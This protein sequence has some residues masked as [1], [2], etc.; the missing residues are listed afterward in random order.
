MP[1]VNEKLHA[2][3]DNNKLYQVF[4]SEIDVRRDD[5][6]SRLQQ[7][8][9]KLEEL[10]IVSSTYKKYKN[11]VEQTGSLWQTINATQIA[12]NREIQEK[13]SSELKQ[14]Y[15]WVFDFY[16]KEQNGTYNLDINQIKDVKI[17]N[18]EDSFSNILKNQDQVIASAIN[19]Y[20][21]Y[22][23]NIDGFLYNNWISWGKYDL[24]A[25]NMYYYNLSVPGCSTSQPSDPVLPSA[26]HHYRGC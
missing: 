20:K 16:N 17:P 3:T 12:I 6:L 4:S 21:S 13:L 7:S 26:H 24:P 11:W 19:K 23:T 15:S 10:S 22:T 25:D 1:D 18:W 8:G 9:I 2:K 5:V 14:S